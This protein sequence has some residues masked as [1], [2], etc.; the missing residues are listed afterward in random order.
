LRFRDRLRLYDHCFA[1]IRL[2]H[3]QPRFLERLFGVDARRMPRFGPWLMP[4]FF[5]RRGRRRRIDRDLAH[6][7]G[8][9]Y[10][11]RT[12]LVRGFF[13]ALG[14]LQLMDASLLLDDRRLLRGMWLRRL[15]VP[16]LAPTATASAT[17]AAASALALGLLLSWLLALRLAWLLALLLGLLTLVLARLRMLLLRLPGLT[18]LAL[19]TGLARRLRRALLLLL[20]LLGRPLLGLTV[21]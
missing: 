20:L 2:D 3:H 5:A 1:A 14:R 7:L 19:L 10:R 4:R 18:R 6:R 9:G 12:R 21:P 8:S 13:A 11:R 17:A 16:A 15:A